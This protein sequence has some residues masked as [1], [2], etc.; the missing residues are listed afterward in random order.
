MEVTVEIAK[1]L[2]LL[3]EEFEMIKKILG[4]VPNFTEL[5]IYAVM[6]SEHASYKN[7]IK[8]LKTLPR[9][10]EAIL[11]E[12]GTENAGLVD[13]GDGIA[14]AFKIESHNHPCAVEPYQGAATGVGGINRDIFT[15]GARP[16]AQLNSLRFGNIKLDRTKWHIKG[17]VKGIGDYG[18][19][20]GV[21]VV[22]GEVFFDESFNTNPL[23]NAMS[24]GIVDKN[25]VVSAISKGVGNPV[26]IVG[27]STGKDGIHGSTFASADITDD[28]ADDIPSIQVGDP[29]MEK[30][31][32]EASLE[33]IKTGAIVG[34]QDMGAAGIICSTSEMSE[35]GGCGMKVDLSKVPLRQH[36]IEAWE[37]L[38]SES[39][40]R[41]L[42]V[43]EKGREA[44][45]EAVYRKWDLNC[46]QI[47]E[48]TEGGRL[49]F[50]WKGELVANVP[51]ESL[52]LGGGAPVYER[53]YREPAYYQEYKKFDINSI[54]EPQDL[55]EVARMLINHPNIASKRWVY[56]QYDSMVGTR[57]M[58][59][60]FP[61]SAGV[62]NLKGTN[63]AIV[64]SVDC[65][66]RYVKANPEV[67]AMIAV[68]EAAR[69]IVC[70]GGKP[71]AITNCL[72]FGNPYKPEIYWQFVNAVKGMGKACEKFGTPVT[73]G[74]VSFYNQSTIGGKDEA[75]FPTPTIG[76]LGVLDNKNHHTTLAF[77]EKGHMIFL[78]GHSR[79][80][81][82]SSEYLYTYHGV[83]A[84]PAPYFDLDEEQRL[85]QLVLQ[86]IN[87]NLIQSANDVSDGGLFISL[88]ECATPRNL[89]FDI[90]TDAEIRTDAFLFGEAQGRVIVTVSPSRET[91][92]IDHMMESGI[93]F[94][95]LGH[96][97]K[98]EVRIDD[99]SFGF[100]ADLKKEYE[101]SLGELIVGK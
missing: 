55:Q 13:L 39:Q 35:K 99:V 11:A 10:G 79:N 42:I 6:W 31:L 77:K 32:L 85:Q 51:A 58:G 24:V 48:V 20:F 80:D 2:G 64:L 60:N 16:V 52:V 100:I 63:K 30:L 87:R 4:R 75:V 47:G 66:S 98:S 44:E 86:L 21:P 69:N 25:L 28:S 68:A 61:S 84:S 67:G 82:A 81:I 34:M 74:N 92:F 23:V 89:G 1:E 37:I 91:H 29:F 41:M 38:L 65:N 14:C 17:V 26:F 90:T 93:P 3:P 57:N 12:A 54:P 43:V 72:N 76:M 59:T 53:E 70:T 49:E 78:I 19:A 18:N 33:V 7:S 46:V 5:S 27:S 95:A 96:V 73:G 62:V 71:L 9:K 40:E 45:V 101:N 56:E 36:N 94:T 88:F 83:K 15:M 97:T 8:W 50:F 22:A